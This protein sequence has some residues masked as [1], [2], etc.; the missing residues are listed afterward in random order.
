MCDIAGIMNFSASGLPSVY[1]LCK[2]VWILRHRG[3][4]ETGIYT[5][6]SVG[7]GHSRL[8]IFCPDHSIQS[9]NNEGKVL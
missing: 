9:V 3:P 7:R 8:S 2:M 5:D 6:Q 1:F 4:D